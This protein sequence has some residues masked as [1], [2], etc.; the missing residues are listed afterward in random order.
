M[1]GDLTVN[2]N[3]AKNACHFMTIDAERSSSLTIAGCNGDIDS[4]SS[5][6]LECPPYDPMTQNCKFEG[7]QDPSAYIH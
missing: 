3:N 6:T 2:C 1:N 4:C 5:M 7:I